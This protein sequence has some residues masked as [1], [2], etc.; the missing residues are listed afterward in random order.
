MWISK[1]KLERIKYAEYT[2]GLSS[3]A[4]ERRESQQWDRIQKLEKSVRKLKKQVKN[5]Y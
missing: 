5:G 1:K 2:Q 3:G 4:E